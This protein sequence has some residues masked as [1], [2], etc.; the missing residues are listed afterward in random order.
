MTAPD[1]LLSIGLPVYNGERYLD[2]S[3]DSL[4]AQT[5]R[6]FELVISDNAST[7][8]TEEIC[9]KYASRDSRI[10][11]FRSPVN[12]GAPQNYRR[13]FDLSSGP[14]FKW[15]TSDD[16][17]APDFIQRCMD[18]V[19]ADPGIVLAYTKS[20]LVD[21]HGRFIADVDQDVAL[22]SSSANARFRQVHA[23]LDY[24]NVIYGLIRRDVLL[25]TGGLGAYINS[26]R[27]LVAELAL[28]GRLHE[29]PVVLFS[30]RMHSG[31][32]SGQQSLEAR[33]KFYNPQRRRR[34]ALM[35]TRSLWE[36]G[37]AIRR[38]PVSVAEKLRL[39]GYLLRVM[40]WQRED[41]VREMWDAS[42]SVAGR[43]VR[44]GDGR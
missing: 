28:H 11:Y 4:L 18:A 38:S 9:R 24:C 41:L 23:H 31:A 43:L 34:V 13:V 2:E 33:L 3:L 26:D 8:R 21:E 5:Y 17:I 27:V 6:D 10:R 7:D 12:V 42:L 40:N 39:G 30:R 44:L 19:T 37:R 1:R 14:Y 20:Q 35:G 22:A 15:H 36:Y 29:V 16:L 25:R 32:Y